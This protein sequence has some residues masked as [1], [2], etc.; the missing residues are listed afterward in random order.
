LPDKDKDWV[1]AKLVK[2][3]G[4]PGPEQGLYN[5]KSLAAQL[6]KNYPSAAASLREGLEEMFTVA[7]LGVDGRLAKTLTTSNLIES[8]ISI[9]RTTNRN[10][11]RWRDGQMVLR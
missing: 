6:D 5:A 11:S 3:F 2:A 1:D 7:R 10:V 9:A 8:M 4:H